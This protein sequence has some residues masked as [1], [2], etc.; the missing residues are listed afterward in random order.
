MS[1]AIILQRGYMTIINLLILQHK[2][3]T[4]EILQHWSNVHLSKDSRTAC[5]SICQLLAG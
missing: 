1:E 2:T 5:H 4:A 3:W